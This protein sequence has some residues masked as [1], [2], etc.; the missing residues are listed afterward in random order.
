MDIRETIECIRQNI[1]EIIDIV[2]HVERC[3][4]INGQYILWKQRTK[5]IQKKPSKDKYYVEKRYITA[6]SARWRQL[7]RQRFKE[8]LQMIKSY[9]K[10]TQFSTNEC[11][12]LSFSSDTNKSFFHSWIRINKYQL[13]ISVQFFLISEHHFSISIRVKLGSKSAI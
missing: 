1:K 13:I 2:E 6:G 8:M 12:N 7:D 4:N 3:K 11:I 9:R 10:T 5:E